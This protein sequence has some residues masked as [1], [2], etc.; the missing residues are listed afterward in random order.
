MELK[1]HGM[2]CGFCETTIQE[3]LDKVEGVLKAKVN[4]R[5]ERAY[6]TIDSQKSVS[7]EDLIKAVKEIGYDAEIA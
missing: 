3:A 7:A 2:T 5:K 6:V 4:L 1:I